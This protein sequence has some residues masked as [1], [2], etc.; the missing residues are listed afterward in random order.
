MSGQYQDFGDDAES[1]AGDF[2]PITDQSDHEDFQADNQLDNNSPKVEKVTS[3]R[4]DSEAD[5]NTPENDVAKPDVDDSLEGRDAA[6]R[7]LGGDDVEEDG[8]G[9]IEEDED[10]D[11]EEDEDEDTVRCN[12]T[13]E[14]NTSPDANM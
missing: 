9:R 2:N 11:D 4:P 6:E 1:D 7:T 10:E 13:K 3:P 12:R 8:G 14:S 5:L